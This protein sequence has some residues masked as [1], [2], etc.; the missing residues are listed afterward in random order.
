[1]GLV[2]TYLNNSELVRGEL[3]TIYSRRDEDWS[4]WQADIRKDLAPHYNISFSDPTRPDDISKVWQRRAHKRKKFS[5]A[6]GF[7]CAELIRLAKET[8]L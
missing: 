1:M 8:P 3:H 7:A 5:D 2:L 6:I 4:E